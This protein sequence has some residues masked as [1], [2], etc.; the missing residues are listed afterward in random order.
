MNLNRSSITH[1]SFHPINSLDESMGSKVLPMRLDQSVTYAPGLYIS[2]RQTQVS[3]PHLMHGRRDDQAHA[4]RHRPQQNG[5]RDV[6]LLH[7]LRPQMVRRQF[8]D[9]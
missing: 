6:L 1:V 5:Q 2:T 4:D 9:D 3:A 8:V 7:D